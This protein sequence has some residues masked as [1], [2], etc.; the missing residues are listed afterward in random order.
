MKTRWYHTVPVVTVAA[1]AAQPAAAQTTYTGPTDGSWHEPTYWDFGVPNA[2]IQAVIPSGKSCKIYN[3]QPA[4]AADS[5]DVDGTLT[6]QA[7]QTLTIDDDSQI[8]G[9]VILEGDLSP[10]GAAL[11][12]DDDVTITGNGGEIQMW[13]IYSVIDTTGSDTLTLE[14]DCT[15]TFSVDCGLSIIGMGEINCALVNNGFV[16]ADYCPPGAGDGCALE[17]NGIPTSGDGD[18]QARNYGRLQVEVEITGPGT[19]RIRHPLNNSSAIIEVNECHDELT[20]DV[21]IEN[22]TL[23]I[24][25]DFCTTGDLTLASTLL[26]SLSYSEPAIDVDADKAAWFSWGACVSCE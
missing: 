19:W 25:E 13:S 2:G 7:Q 15:G 11:L 26:G 6:I 17:I 23:R 16:I 8:D 22:G 18:W 9:T 14:S 10:S 1:L 20:G 24:N 21:I 3:G 12:I 5:I 4:A